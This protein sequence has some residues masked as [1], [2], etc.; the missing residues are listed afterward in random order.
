MKAY[1]VT[2]GTIFALFAAMHFFIT[3]E[4]WRAPGSEPS[5]VLIPA[6]IAAFSTSLAIWAVYLTRRAGS[7]AL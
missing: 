6:A 2:T 3:F 1:L 7:A 4:H 5:A